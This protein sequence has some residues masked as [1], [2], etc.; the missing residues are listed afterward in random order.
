[1]L[2]LIVFGSIEYCCHLKIGLI[3]ACF[4]L[5]LFDYLQLTEILYFVRLTALWIVVGTVMKVNILS[6]YP[7][8]VPKSGVL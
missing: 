3:K 7:V 1:M 4:P 2:Q 8:L 5:S 6:A